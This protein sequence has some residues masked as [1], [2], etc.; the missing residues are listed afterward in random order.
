[1]LKRHQLPVLV[2]SFKLSEN[3]QTKRRKSRLEHVKNVFVSFS[4]QKIRSMFKNWGTWLGKENENGHVKEE[5]EAVVEDQNQDINKQ[6]AGG[7]SE[8]ARAA[9]GDA[10]P[11]QLLLKAKGFSGESGKSWKSRW[12]T[13]CCNGGLRLDALL[14]LCDPCN[15]NNLCYTCFSTGYIYNFASS[16]SKKLSE[17]VVETAQTLKKTVEE[18]KI[19]GIIDKVDMVMSVLIYLFLPSSSFYKSLLMCFLPSDHFGWFPERTRKVCSGEQS[20]KA[21]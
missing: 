10:Q 21:W 16:A 17:S 11:T 7:E 13:C 18:G 5:G 15:I 1:M 20:E 8:Q 19:N 14:Q 2:F 9:E 6:T 12:S 4:D 3:W